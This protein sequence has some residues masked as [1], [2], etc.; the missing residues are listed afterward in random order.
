EFGCPIVLC[1]WARGPRIVGQDIV[2][3]VTND[4]RAAIGQA[5]AAGV[6]PGQVIIDPGIGFGKVAEES[7]EV[8]RRLDE[9]K[10]ALP[11]PLLVGPSRK[12]FIG[13]VLGLPTE[14]QLEGTAAAVT[15]SIARGAD[16]VRVHD[17]LPMARVAKVADAIVRGWAPPS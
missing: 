5:M 3:R 14:A 1:H 2:A 13:K 17:V 7:L 6:A 11:Y 15:A 12:S 10:A 16:I 4:L 9:L 8:L